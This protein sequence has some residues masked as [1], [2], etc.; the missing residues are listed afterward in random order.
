MEMKGDFNGRLRSGGMPLYRDGLKIMVF[1]YD[2]LILL[3]RRG[4]ANGRRTGRMKH[5]YHHQAQKVL[6]HAVQFFDK[7]VLWSSTNGEVLTNLNS[8][9][10]DEI[11]LR[12]YGAEWDGEHLVKNLVNLTT[13][14]QILWAMENEPDMSDVDDVTGVPFIGFTPTDRVIRLGEHE[15][16]MTKYKTIFRV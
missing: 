2:D 11:D 14:L 10:F 15:N 6:R 16:F 9:P 12:V 4:Y 13:D 1:D 7:T 5:R 8:S 3:H